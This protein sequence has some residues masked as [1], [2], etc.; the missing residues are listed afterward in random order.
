[1]IHIQGML[2]Q[3][4]EVTIANEYFENAGISEPSEDMY[5]AIQNILCLEVSYYLARR[6]SGCDGYIIDTMRSLRR[7][8]INEYEFNYNNEYLDFNKHIDF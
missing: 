8:L 7:R 3:S 2:D 4:M 5:D 1:M 6:T